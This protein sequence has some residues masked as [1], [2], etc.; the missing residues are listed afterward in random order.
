MKFLKIFNAINFLI[1]IIL[2]Y[3]V[4]K[5][6]KK[7]KNQTDMLSDKYSKLRDKLLEDGLSQEEKDKILQEMEE[8]FRKSYEIIYK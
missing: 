1:S 4:Y 2:L 5:G 7:K 8:I 3:V 6:N